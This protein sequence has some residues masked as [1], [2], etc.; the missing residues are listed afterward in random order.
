MPPLT[1]TDRVK[2]KLKSRGSS[3]KKVIVPNDTNLSQEDQITSAATHTSNASL[4][5]K[6]SPAGNQP[7]PVPLPGKSCNVPPTGQ[8]IRELWHVAYEELRNAEKELVQKFEEKVSA[9]LPTGLASTAG[10][11]NQKREQMNTIV[12]RKIEEVDREAWRIKFGSSDVLVKDLLASCV[13]IVTFLKKSLEPVLNANPYS[14]IA[15][16]GVSLLLPV[17]ESVALFIKIPKYRVLATLEPLRAGHVSREGTG[18][19]CNSRRTEPNARRSLSPA[20]R[21]EDK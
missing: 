2:Q 21:V 18:V 1:F 14:S 3:S 12:R 16:M 10:F 9:S 13:G 20:L 11:N 8:P 7:V 15:W 4:G 17:S 19:R 6:S 5:P